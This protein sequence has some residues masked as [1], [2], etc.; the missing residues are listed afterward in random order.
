MVRCSPGGEWVTEQIDPLGIADPQIALGPDNTVHV[1]YQKSDGPDD[2]IRFATRNTDGSWTIETLHHASMFTSDLV[3]DS[4]GTPHAVYSHFGDPQDTI[5]YATKN[6]AGDWVTELLPDCRFGVGIDV[7]VL[8]RPHIACWGLDG[9]Q[10]YL[11][12]GSDW[13]HETVSDGSNIVPR[14]AAINTGL[15]PAIAVDGDLNPHISFRT[16]TSSGFDWQTTRPA[17]LHYATKVDGEW[18]LET[19]DR[20][21]SYNGAWSSITL[22]A[23][24]RP[25][26]SYVH[27]WRRFGGFPSGSEALEASRDL[28]YATPLVGSVASAVGR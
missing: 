3:I 6:Q 10:Y 21:G 2:E 15:E 8:D 18:S 28:R 11:K 5:R 9:L 12:D 14:R 26:I 24:D 25:H 27:V 22:D 16:R 20:D 23:E 19:V 1:F 7:D 17:Q 4:T 13:I